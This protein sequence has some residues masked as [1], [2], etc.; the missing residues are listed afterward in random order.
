[1]AHYSLTDVYVRRDVVKANGKLKQLKDMEFWTRN[2]GP[3]D[4]SWGNL[5]GQKKMHNQITAANFP[6]RAKMP[7]RAFPSSDFSDNAVPFAADLIQIDIE[8]PAARRFPDC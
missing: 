8:R 3:N 1:M 2:A 5:Y 6:S 7:A 4:F